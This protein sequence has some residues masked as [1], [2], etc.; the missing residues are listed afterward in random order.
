MCVTGVFSKS[1]KIVESIIEASSNNS[2]MS[3]KKQD[4]SLCFF[5]LFAFGILFIFFT[6]L[7]IV[8]TNTI[9]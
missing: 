8:N 9:M 4:L 7:F 5:L 1:K 3:F 2:N 6:L